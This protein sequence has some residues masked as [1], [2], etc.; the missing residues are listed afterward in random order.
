VTEE[1]GPQPGA[2]A[3]APSV[4]LA[5]VIAGAVSLGAY[6]AGALTA[7]TRLIRESKGAIVVD[8][9]AGASAGS[10]TAVLLAHALLTGAG[11]DD[12]QELWVTLTSIDTMLKG[13]PKPGRPPAPLSTR[14]LEDWAAGAVARRGTPIQTEPIATVLS[15]TNIRGLRYRI[16]QGI[17]GRTVPADTF[18]DARTFLLTPDTDWAGPIETALASAANAF[19]FAPVQME[20]RRE[21]YPSE[22]EFPATRAAFWYTDGGT[23]YNE[24]LGFAIDAIND[25]GSLRI[26][27]ERPQGGERLF[28][29]VHPDPSSPP[30]MWPVGGGRPTFRA[31]SLRSWLKLAMSQSLLDDLRRME[32]TNSRI[33]ARWQVQTALSTLLGDVP[34]EQ[35]SAMVR[36]MSA[37]A[38]R[39]KVVV[40]GITGRALDERLQ[41]LVDAVEGAGTLDGGTMMELLDFTLDEA[42]GTGFKEVF[43]VEVVSPELDPSGRSPHDLLAGEKMAHFFGFALVAAR[44]SDFGLGYTHFRLWWERFASQPPPG[45]P[46]LPA[47]GIPPH[48][49]EAK[50]TGGELGLASLG[51]WRK[52][53]LG[54]RLGIRYVREMVRRDA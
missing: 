18:R 3:V 25:P 11:E 19:A 20:R 4:R 42:T 41:R 53:W 6:E 39:R 52:L 29:L 26:D 47:L 23:V 22:V 7:L 43:D 21:E 12:L 1:V 32:K 9:I 16:A 37:N 51:L 14:L 40:R 54:L 2:A 34:A 27:R 36:S 49:L 48:P 15:V 24:P 50:A 44:E 17:S 13:R 10:I 28:L 8:T 38:V 5:L 45:W 30:A 35:A 33:V 31:A 46:A